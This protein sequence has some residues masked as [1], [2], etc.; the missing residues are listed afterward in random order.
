MP[1]LAHHS[2]AGTYN[3]GSLLT[4]RGEIIQAFYGNPH[5]WFDLRVKT[6]TGKV[7][8]QRVEIAAPRR[9]AQTGFDRNRL[10][11]GSDIAVETWI[12]KDIRHTDRLSGRTVILTDG[13]RFD[14]ADN[15][16]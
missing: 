2:V 10:D 1:C 4:V 15:W 14:V 5:V 6:E 9:L 7:L 8:T 12:S 11:V 16:H 3:T 13:R